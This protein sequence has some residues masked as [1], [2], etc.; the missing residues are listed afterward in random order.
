V[1]FPA[2]ELD[3]LLIKRWEVDYDEF[4]L[5]DNDCDNG[6]FVDLIENPERFT[7]YAGEPANK[8]WRSIYDENC[9]TPTMQSNPLANSDWNKCEE[10]QTFYRIV[11]GLHAS[12]STHLAHEWFN[13]KTNS[14]VPTSPTWFA[15]NS[16]C[17]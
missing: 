6:V 15:C 17:M 1:S 16:V 9:F 3:P 4:C 10:R 12:I 5:M 2:H 8:I 11:S 14:W 13:Q 7:G